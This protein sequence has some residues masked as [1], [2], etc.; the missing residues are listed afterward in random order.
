[1]GCF[2]EL[3]IFNYDICTMRIVLIGAGSVA[4][5]L[6]MALKKAGHAIVEVHSHTEESAK[7]LARILKAY[8]NS[9]PDLITRTGDIYILSLPDHSITSF[10][11]KFPVTDKIIVHTSGSTGIRV[12]GKRFDQCGVL[13]PLQTFSRE[14]KVN[15]QTVPLLIEGSDPKTNATLRN[16]ANS[17][18]GF[19]F[20]MDSAERKTVHLSAVIANNFTNHLFFQA[21]KILAKKNIPFSLLGPLLLETVNKA[22]RLSPGIAQTGPA[23]RGDRDTIEEHL[24]MLKSKPFLQKIYRMMSESI[25]QDS[26]RRL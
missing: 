21:E 7:R 13:Y 6:G 16:L 8:P 14:H 15:L 18:S 24:L 2:F 4:T 19:V 11:K 25:Q 9:D 26:G 5:N 23:K 22:I 20:E 10:L 3:R 17:V 1:M 12:F